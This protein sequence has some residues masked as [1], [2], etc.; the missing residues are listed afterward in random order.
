[1]GHQIYFFVAYSP[2]VLSQ[3][4]SLLVLAQRNFSRMQLSSVF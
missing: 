1:M 2:L 3:V 4:Y